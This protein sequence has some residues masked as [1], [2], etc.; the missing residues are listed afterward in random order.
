[1]HTH[2]THI[3][4]LVMAAILSTLPL[5]AYAGVWDT[6]TG[7]IQAEAASVIIGGV[8]GALGMFGV[9]YKLWGKAAKELGDV[10]YWVYRAVQPN[11]PGGKEIVRDEMERILREGAEVYPAVTAAIAARKGA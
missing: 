11:S 3:R 8:I 2:V 9:A 5:A 4:T 10:V 1:M 6:V 7:Y